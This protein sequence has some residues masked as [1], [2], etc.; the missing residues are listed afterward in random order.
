[1]KK[2]DVPQSGSQA[3]TT[4]SR[5]R[6][7]QYN[8]T[9]SIPTQPRTAAQVNVRANFTAATKEW[10]NLTDEQRQAWDTYANSKPRVDSL[11]QSSTLTGH[12]MYVAVNALNLTCEIEQQSA[13]PNG[14]VIP[15]PDPAVTVA[16][17]AGLSVKLVTA[18]PA[19]RTIVVYAS[20]PMSAGQTF[21]GDFRIV[22]IVDGSAAANQEV[23]GAAD[24]SAKYGTLSENMKFM[25]SVMVLEGGNLSAPA[26]ISTKLTA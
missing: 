16:T 7:G 2:I 5:N 8:R 4:A 12:Q 6:F 9:R 11:G 13:V 1:M 17:F 26:K 19:T 25:F 15:Q 20:P 14:D 10:A 24:L 21:N 18:V 22:N 3:N 23:C